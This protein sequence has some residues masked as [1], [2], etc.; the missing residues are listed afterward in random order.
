VLVLGRVRVLS[1]PLALQDCMWRCFT[2]LQFHPRRL[3]VIATPPNRRL[4]A[5]ED[6]RELLVRGR[7]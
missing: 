7:R 2:A 6:R 5:E 3:V 1:H 4:G